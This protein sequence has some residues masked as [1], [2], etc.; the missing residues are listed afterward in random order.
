MMAL[1]A[2]RPGA[3]FRYNGDNKTKTEVIMIAKAAL[4]TGASSGI[5]RMIATELNADLE[6]L[7]PAKP[8]NASGAGGM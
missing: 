7:K 2:I 4:V 6:E 3:S 8:L 1:Y 5:G